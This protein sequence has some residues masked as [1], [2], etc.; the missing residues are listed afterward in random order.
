MDRETIIGADERYAEKKLG[1]LLTNAT[2][3]LR[4][5]IG[6]SLELDGMQPTKL[7]AK[8]LEAY[9]GHTLD[10]SSGMKVTLA[11]DSE[12]ERLTLKQLDAPIRGAHG[13]AR[14]FRT[15][16]LGY[17]PS[18]EINGQAY[19]ARGSI[20]DSSFAEGLLSA[21]SIDQAPTQDARAYQEWRDT[22]LERTSGWHLV[23][24][25]EI[26]ETATLDTVQFSTLQKEATLN[27]AKGV[28][29][30]TRSFTRS[31]V[32]F[33]NETRHHTEQVLEMSNNVGD[34]QLVQYL[35]T[36]SLTADN[37]FVDYLDIRTNERLQVI[38][39]TEDSHIDTARALTDAIHARHLIK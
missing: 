18:I 36:F 37:P 32:Q 26:P 38:P 4:P 29:A 24:K 8:E 30:S 11:Y 23:E 5:G 6:Y 15:E 31:I 13:V 1:E 19:N 7:A 39:L 17:V 22:L 3:S 16:T 12:N 33:D 10:T 27:L 21:F 20:M 28:M 2:D 34:I 35:K 14:L 25:L 9:F